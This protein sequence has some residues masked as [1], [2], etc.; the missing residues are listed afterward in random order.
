M[1]IQVEVEIFDD[2]EYCH[3]EKIECY[4]L[5]EFACRLYRTIIQCGKHK[6]PQCKEAMSKAERIK[7]DFDITNPMGEEKHSLE[8]VST[9]QPNIK[10]R[11]DIKVHEPGG[12]YYNNLNEVANG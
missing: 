10:D 7:K 2:P 9:H 6:C 1:K 12:K 11:H 5:E 8:K 4:Y 3:D